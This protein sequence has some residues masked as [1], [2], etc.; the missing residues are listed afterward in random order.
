MTFGA[1]LA[2]AALAAV[3]VAGCGESSPAT[4]TSSIVQ[5]PPVGAGK[6]IIGRGYKLYEEDG[7]AGCHSLSGTRLTGPT[8]KGLAGSTVQLADGR[9]VTATNKYLT[10]HILDPNA[11]TVKGY[12]GEVMAAAIEELHL[13]KHPRDVAALVA[14]IDSLRA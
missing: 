3:A 11:W 14:F 8:W 5:T 6:G 2:A 9:T 4:T 1:A 7:C 10:A 13:S 12:P